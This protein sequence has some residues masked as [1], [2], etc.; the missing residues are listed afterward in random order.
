MGCHFLLQCMKVKSES[1]VAQSCPTLCNPRDCSLPGSSIHGS[2][3]ARVLEWA[4][5]AFSDFY[6]TRRIKRIKIT[7]SPEKQLSLQVQVGNRTKSN[8]R[9]RNI[10]Q[11]QAQSTPPFSVAWLALTPPRSHIPQTGTT[12]LSTRAIR[13]WGPAS[14]YPGLSTAHVT[15]H[16]YSL[17]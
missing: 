3:Q 10:K 4:A 14:V 16:E 13:T 2:F 6:S 5:I 9:S 1:E 12:E 15:L 11:W 8:Y 7:R 17:V